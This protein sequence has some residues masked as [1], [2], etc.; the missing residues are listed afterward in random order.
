MLAQ[1]NKVRLR[2]SRASALTCEVR[3]AE[4]RV[5]LAFPQTYMNRSGESVSLLLRRYQLESPQCLVVI[6][7]ELDLPPGTV[8]VKTGGG[9]A[10]H[11]GLASLRDCLGTVEFTRVRI[12]IGKPPSAALGASYVLKSAPAAQ[13]KLLAKAVERDAEAVECIVA[14]GADAAMGSFNSR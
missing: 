9:L 13:L 12:G 1:R 10:G 7:D 3:M 5:V 14:E 4:K 6:H 8:R 2:R 11:H